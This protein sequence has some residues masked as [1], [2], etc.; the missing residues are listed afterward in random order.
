MHH[1]RNRDHEHFL[2]FIARKI[3]KC[4]HCHLLLSA[5]SAMRN[6]RGFKSF[7]VLLSNVRRSSIRKYLEDSSTWKV[8][9][10][11]REAIKTQDV[12]VI[13]F[14]ID[15]VPTKHLHIKEDPHAKGSACKK[16]LL[17]HFPSTPYQ[18]SRARRTSKLLNSQ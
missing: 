6:K 3:R 4:A 14:D 8:Q 2:K 9:R 18:M 7:L 5:Q 13:Q 1:S 15:D 11:A 12:G 16:E 17:P 10:L